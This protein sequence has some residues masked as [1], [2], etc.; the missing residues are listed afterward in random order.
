M[1]VQI[2]SM[3]SKIAHYQALVVFLVMAFTGYYFLH[4][5]LSFQMLRE[6][7]EMLVSFRD[8]NYIVAVVVFILAY[9]LFVA[10]SVP[11]GLI[12]SI[13]GGFLFWT[14]PGVFYNMIGATLGATII[15]F[16]ARWGFGARLAA[17]LANSEGLVKKIK[18][19]ISENQ[20]SMLFL[21]RLIPGVPFFLANLVPSFLDVSWRRFVISTFFG[22]FP[23]AL[24]FTSIGAGLGEIFERGENPDLGIF[25]EPQ[26][27]FPILGLCALSTLPI[28]LKRIRAKTGL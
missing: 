16:A 20:W 13:T 12:L 11:G 23:G 22:I 19:G 24:V 6:H 18:D 26:I 15:F 5:Y 21:I 1:Y 17:S 10:F 2:T 8:S 14:F 27:I 7:R 4:D 28:I 25:W 3:L 9:T